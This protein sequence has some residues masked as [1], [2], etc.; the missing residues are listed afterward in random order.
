MGCHPHGV[1]KFWAGYQELRTR[2]TISTA[3][4][5]GTSSHLRGFQRDWSTDQ[6]AAKPNICYF[7]V[8]MLLL[9]LKAIKRNFHLRDT[10]AS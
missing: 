9:R 6:Q 2:E 5:L 3:L 7:V 1:L 8:H 10:L 4:F